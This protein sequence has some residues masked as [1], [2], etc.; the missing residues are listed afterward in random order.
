M[1][2]LTCATCGAKLEITNDIDRFACSFCGNE[3]IVQR[4]GG[5]V[6]LKPVV[7]EL[8]KI[9]ANT[10]ISADSNEITA[11]NTDVLAAEAKL[12]ILRKKLKE[13]QK[14]K[15]SINNESRD[16]TS[17]CGCGCTG[18]LGIIVVSLIFSA[19][20]AFFEHNNQ[21]GVLSIIIAVL[22][23]V[24]AYYI[25]SREEDSQTEATSI[26]LAKNS[27]ADQ[28]IRELT[29]EICKQEERILGG[30]NPRIE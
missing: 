14:E 27:D 13:A 6:S 20:N 30:K 21:A 23:A 7:D 4:T 29:Y 1:I 24:G 8:R 3:F 16:S 28:K 26:F 17:G 25:Y 12:K 9:S 5:I 10:R 22:L 2:R 18:C 15:D 11:E 19:I